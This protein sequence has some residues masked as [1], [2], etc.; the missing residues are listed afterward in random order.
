MVLTMAFNIKSRRLSAKFHK[1]AGAEATSAGSSPSKDASSLFLS[2]IFHSQDTMTGVL[3]GFSLSQDAPS[4]FL[5]AEKQ[6]ISAQSRPFVGLANFFAPQSRPPSE[7]AHFF[8]AHSRPSI[9]P[10][11]FF[12]SFSRSRRQKSIHRRS[13][14]R[15]VD[16]FL[17]S[18]NV[19]RYYRSGSV[20]AGS[21]SSSTC[22]ASSR[23]SSA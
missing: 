11:Y 13:S 18:A 8:P 5:R 2:A 20:I 19:R 12:A 6:W 1:I 10:A 7:V 21:A 14:E 22:G 16:A 4:L 23:S 15:L 3:I 17:Y 9:G